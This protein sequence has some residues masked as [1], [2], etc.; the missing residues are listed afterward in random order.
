M[1]A[2]GVLVLHAV[3]AAAARLVL[4]DDRVALQEVR[5]THHGLGAVGEAVELSLLVRVCKRAKVLPLD[6]CK[7]SKFLL[8]KKRYL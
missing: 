2:P 3:L 8:D 5:P 6:I 7:Y 4:D 1:V